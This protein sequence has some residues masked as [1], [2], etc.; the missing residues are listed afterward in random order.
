MFS[1]AELLFGSCNDGLVSCLRTCVVCDNAQKPEDAQ[2]GPPCLPQCKRNGEQAHPRQDV[3]HIHHCLEERGI[4]QHLWQLTFQER[5]TPETLMS[6]DNGLQMVKLAEKAPLHHGTLG[7]LKTGQ[8][9][10]T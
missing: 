10:L 8:C 7:V 3:E 9:R 4:A 6:L 5:S 1:K 2:A